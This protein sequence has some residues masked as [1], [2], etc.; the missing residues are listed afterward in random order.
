MNAFLH[1]LITPGPTEARFLRWIYASPARRVLEIILGC[2]VTWVL[3]FVYGLLV[4]LLVCVVADAPGRETAFI[5]ISISLAAATISAGFFLYKDTR[6]L[7]CLLLP[8]YVIL[9]LG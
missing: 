4:V 2:S 8:I 1:W 7:R 6:I 3:S 5:T 9:E